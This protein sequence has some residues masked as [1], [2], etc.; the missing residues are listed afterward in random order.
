MILDSPRSGQEESIWREMT[1]LQEEMNRLFSR[2]QEPRAGGF[3]A[4]NL[5]A[6]QESAVVTTELPGVE[7]ADIDISVVGDT[8]TIQGVRR[9]NEMGEGSNYHRRERGFGRFVRAMQLP[10]RVE[11][12]EVSAT[13]RN[14][15]LSITLPRAQADRPRKVQ[16]KSA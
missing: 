10:F 9:P 4:I 7:Q 8:L 3:P 5:W 16:I 11:P 2:T 15:T 12:N 6:S 14:G 1:R 13:L